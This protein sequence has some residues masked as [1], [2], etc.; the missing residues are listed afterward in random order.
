MFCLN[1]LPLFSSNVVD[2]ET[3][4]VCSSKIYKMKLYIRKNVQKCIRRNTQE[5]YR[6]IKKLT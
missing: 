3:V 5:T 1:A 4:V 2:F 6:G